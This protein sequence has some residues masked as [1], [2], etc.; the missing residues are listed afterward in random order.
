VADDPS[1]TGRVVDSARTSSWRH[2]VLPVVLSLSLAFGIQSFLLQAFYIPSGSME[3]TCT[4]APAV[5][6]T[7]SSWTR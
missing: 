5:P 4:A 6:A 1:T 2:V 7:A 3:R